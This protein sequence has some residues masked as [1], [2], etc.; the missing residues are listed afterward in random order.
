VAPMRRYILNQ[1]VEISLRLYKIYIKLKAVYLIYS[2]T[3]KTK[4]NINDR[5]QGFKLIFFNQIT[6][7]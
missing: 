2:L 5:K 6:T 3:S 1:Q 4:T 7:Y